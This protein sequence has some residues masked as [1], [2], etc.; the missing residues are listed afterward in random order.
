M[1][2]NIILAL[3]A[4][5]PPVLS[6]FLTYKLTSKKIR[7]D[8]EVKIKTQFNKLSEELRNELKKELDECRNDRGNLRNELNDYKNKLDTYKKENEN[9]QKELNELEIKLDDANELI[10]TLVSGNNINISNKRKV[11]V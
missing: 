6:A 11:R 7:N 4:I 2:D 10:K 8:S 3:I 1:K 5:V 9:L